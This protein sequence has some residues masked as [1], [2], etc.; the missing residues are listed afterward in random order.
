M[1][2]ALVLGTLL[3]S[4]PISASAGTFTISFTWDGLKLCRT[5][6]PN[7]VENPEFIVSGLPAGTTKVNFRLKDKNVPSYNHGGGTV[8]MSKDGVVPRG[9]FKYESPCPPS[10]SH[11]YEWTATAK[12]NLKVLG[13]AKAVRNYPE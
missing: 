3:V 2:K 11:K 8:K 12:A 5:G 1:F 13:K 6:R 9:M 10:G 7:I 4:L